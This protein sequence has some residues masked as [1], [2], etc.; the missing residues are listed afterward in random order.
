MRI[1]PLC[2]QIN[3]WCSHE[4]SC[5]KHPQLLIRDAT[6][7]AKIA[8]QVFFQQKLLQLWLQSQD[9]GHTGFCPVENTVTVTTSFL[10]NSGTCYD[11][12]PLSS[13]TVPNTG[14]LFS[15]QL[16]SQDFRRGSLLRWIRLWR[17]RTNTDWAG[18]C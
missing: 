4:C 11:V 9:F 2:S 6:V 17:S 16:P 3:L 10:F 1:T 7:V 13:Q 5:I 15:W 18:V 14:A 12:A 8:Y